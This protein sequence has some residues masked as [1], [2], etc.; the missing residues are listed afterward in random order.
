MCVCVRTCVRAYVCVYVRVCGCVCVC[1][2]TCVCV[3]VYVRVCVRVC[4]C[5]SMYVCVHVC[6]YVCAC[7]CVC[8]RV[9]VYVCVPILCFRFAGSGSGV[10]LQRLDEHYF[11][12]DPDVFIYS[13]F[14][15]DPAWQLLSE[16]W[17]LDKFEQTPV[18]SRLYHHTAWHLADKHKAVGFAADGKCCISM[19]EVIL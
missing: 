17:T 9:Y 2:C 18:F 8:V 6:M 1:L 19:D 10:K 12:T 11:L 15:E 7:V 14:A 4:M 5:V 3:C 16:P 13:S